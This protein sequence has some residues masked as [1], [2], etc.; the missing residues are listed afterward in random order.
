MLHFTPTSSSWM[1]LVERFFRDL[2]QDAI[3]DES[4]ANVAELIAAINTYLAERNL[5]PKSTSGE[6][7]E[8]RFSGG[9]R[10]HAPPCPLDLYS[11]F[12]NTTLAT[13]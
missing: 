3:R 9:S 5:A 1:N 4:F 7:R 8:Q 11:Y 12:G 13:R 10:R 6:Q 2:T